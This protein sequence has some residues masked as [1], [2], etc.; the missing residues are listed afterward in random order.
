MHR[1]TEA[2]IKHMRGKRRRIVQRRRRQAAA[3]V[4]AL[5][6]ALSAAV[7]VAGLTGTDL[8]DA[9]ASR[10]RSFID[11]MD[12][13]SPGARTAAQLTKTKARHEV[14]AEREAAPSLPE[15]LAHI[16]APVPSLVPV[17]LG[18]PAIPELTLLTAPTPPLFF[19]PLPGGGVSGCCAGG[20]GGGSR[21]GGGGG[22]DTVPEVPNVP[23]PVPEPSTWMSMLLGFGLMGWL[24]R[25]NRG[26]VAL[27]A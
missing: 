27:A 2:V 19:A 10:A 9:A 4:G 6:L 13:R 7:G 14:L 12:Q 1:N 22:T 21:G 3:G 23:P 11:L 18:P 25:R 8:A 16:L 17:D 24:L 26:A 5:A 15:N 20:G